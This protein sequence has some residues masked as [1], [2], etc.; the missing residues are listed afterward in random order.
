V[1]RP[2]PSFGSLQT[3]SLDNDRVRIVV[4]PELGARVISFTDRF[5]DRVWGVA[6]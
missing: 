3:I 1:I 2:G 5:A 6:G 4:V